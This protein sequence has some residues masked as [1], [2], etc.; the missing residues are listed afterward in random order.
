M[1]LVL[2]AGA[3]L[4]FKSVARLASVDPGFSSD[5]RDHAAVLADRGSLP[6]RP[7]SLRFIERVVTRVRALPGVEAAAAAGQV[8]M[9]GNGDRFGFHIE[10]RCTRQSCGGSVTLSVIP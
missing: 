2:L 5:A 10:G 9:G 3:G 4:M 8:P 7:S 6:G 1:A